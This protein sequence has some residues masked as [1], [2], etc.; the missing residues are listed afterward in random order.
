[1]HDIFLLGFMVAASLVWMLFMRFLASGFTIRELISK[2]FC[3]FIC[4]LIILGY[5]KFVMYPLELFSRRNA[6]IFSFMLLGYVMFAFLLIIKGENLCLFAARLS[7][8]RRNSLFFS[9]VAFCVIFVCVFY[10]SLLYL[11]DPDFFL[12]SFFNTIGSV[13]TYGMTLLFMLILVWPLIPELVQNILSIL[14]AFLVCMAFI[15][16][17]VL[18]ENYGSINELKIDESMIA[19][20]RT[21]I[22]DTISIILTCSIII[23]CIWKKYI[24]HLIAA[25]ILISF[26]MCGV[27]VYC[28]FSISHD[29]DSQ[30]VRDIKF[31][32]YHNRLWRFSKNGNNVVCLFLDGFTGD[33]VIKILDEY[34]E[35]AKQLEGFIYFPDTL[36]TGSRTFASTPSIYGGPDYKINVLNN[37]PDVTV[38]EK[39][40]EA[41]AFLPNIFSAKGYDSVLT[42]VP[43]LRLEEYQEKLNKPELVMTL[44]SCGAD[45]V[46]YW[47]KWAEENNIPLVAKDSEDISRYLFVLSLFRTM[48]FS[49]RSILYNNGNWTWGV[50]N[51]VLKMR[52]AKTFIPSL[53]LI[54][55]MG[56]FIHVEDCEPTFK[57]LYNGITH[58]M[59]FLPRDSLSPVLDPYPETQGQFILVDGLL[60]EHYYTEVHI[61]GFVAKFVA[62][63]KSLGV[64]DNTRIVIVSDHDLGDSWQMNKNFGRNGYNGRP[65][66]ILMFKDFNTHGDLITSNA[67][68]SIEDNAALLISRIAKAPGIYTLE[69]LKKLSSS[70]RIRIHCGLSL[71]YTISPTLFSLDNG[72]YQVKGSM[73]KPENWT[74][75]E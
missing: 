28:Y 46:P 21:A 49:V 17:F 47:L 9:S 18:T 7:N 75:I 16:S 6:F 44:P 66:G 5:I 33:H 52:F 4:T 67:L 74:R 39:F 55:F 57:I 53:A 45:Y 29:N 13:T 11:T 41:F 20:S 72:V 58:P 61:L 40:A 25:F 35:L 19:S 34:P 73:F 50:S 64:Y 36:T 71:E 59:W 60:P 68:M 2:F 42:N 38:T 23:F 54:Q 31:P 15:N 10:P 48:P 14:A 8:D 56:D 62:S 65:N 70:D 69:E 27:S 1:M 32:E 22:K 37:R 43:F 12:E 63:L 51:Q 24:K 30:I 26:A 3:I